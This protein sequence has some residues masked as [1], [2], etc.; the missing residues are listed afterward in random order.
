MNLGLPFASYTAHRF[1]LWRFS[2][3]MVATEVGIV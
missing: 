2:A 3:G 1:P